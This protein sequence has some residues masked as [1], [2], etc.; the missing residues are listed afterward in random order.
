[1]KI[2]IFTAILIFLT[3]MSGFAAGGVDVG[4]GG[5]AY[6]LEFQSHAQSLLQHWQELQGY[7]SFK[8]S[9]PVTKENLADAMSK[10]QVHSTTSPLMLGDAEV[11]AKNFPFPRGEI[12]LNRSRW[13]ALRSDPAK[14]LALVLHEYLGVLGI[15]Q[16][17]FDDFYQITAPA[18]EGI[19]N[20]LTKQTRVKVNFVCSVNTWNSHLKTKVPRAV[21]NTYPGESSQVGVS[22]ENGDVQPYDFWIELMTVPGDILAT[23]E[24]DELSYR[25]YRAQPY[26]LPNPQNQIGNGRIEFGQYG[27]RSMRILRDPELELDCFRTFD[28]LGG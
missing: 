14:R 13:D 16:K 23:N 27:K 6:A 17:R 18:F 15:D 25:L 20:I 28:G 24:V 2:R 7:D 9:F 4:N 3:S 21:V 1:M 10:T 11:D 12:Q 26:T 22:L 19:R 5:D 8:N